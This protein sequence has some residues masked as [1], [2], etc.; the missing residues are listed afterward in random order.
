MCVYIYIYTQICYM[1]VHIH[2]YI[3]I[4]VL[5]TY[6]TQHDNTSSIRHVDRRDDTQRKTPKPN[7]R[8]ER[9]QQARRV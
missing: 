2:M 1:Y 4:Y 6:K 5:L 9:L 8:V 3:Y 7:T